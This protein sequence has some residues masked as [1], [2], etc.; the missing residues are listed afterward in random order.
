M[1]P[2]RTLAL[3][4]AS[5]VAVR[6]VVAGQP[7][8]FRAETRLVA[9][10]ATVKN[11]RGELVTNLPQ[12]AFTVYE[13]GQRQPIALFLREDIPVSLGLVI[14]NSGS[15]RPLRSKVEAAALAFAR[16][17]NAQDEMFVL[18]FGDK[19]RLDVP[20]TTDRHELEAGIARVDAIGGTALR[21]AV[22]AAE[23]YLRDHAR[24]DR[25]V[26]LVI[27]DGN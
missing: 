14:D 25:R 12:R 22:E 9:L 11:S 23:T 16:A 27:T 8:P 19:P 1:I 15:M 3:A 17:S 2:R 7:A 21:D 6:A 4:L 24:R 20:L 5:T 10:R 18:N 13:N 26:L